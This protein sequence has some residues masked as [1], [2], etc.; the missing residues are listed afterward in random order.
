M[1]N[2]RKRDKRWN[3]DERQ[4]GEQNNRPYVVDHMKAGIGTLAFMPN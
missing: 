3:G 2:E 4:D 1:E